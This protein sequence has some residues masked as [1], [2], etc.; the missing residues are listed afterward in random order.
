MGK[1]DDLAWDWFRNIAA[2]AEGAEQMAL[3]AEREACCVV[4]MKKGPERTMAASAATIHA[5]NA[6]RYRDAARK[7]CD[8]LRALAEE[9]A[10]VAGHYRNAKGQMEKAE[11]A[12]EN[13]TEAGDTLIGI[14]AMTHTPGENR[15]SGIPVC[16]TLK[17]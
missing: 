1:N 5:W 7:Y 15:S 13:A 4:V 11:R 2:L 12:A 9:D 8:Q 16:K 17:F 10:G 14:V 3:A 6:Q